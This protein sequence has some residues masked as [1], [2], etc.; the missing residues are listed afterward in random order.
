M[1]KRTNISMVLRF[2]GVCGSLPTPLGSS[3]L[4]EKIVITAN[5][6]RKAGLQ[7]LKEVRAFVHK[8]P[9]PQRGT[10]GGN[11]SCVDV[12][13]GD[14][15]LVFDAGSGLKALGTRLLADGFGAGTGEIHIFMSHTHWDHIQGFPF[16]VP[17]Y[18]PGNKI[19]IY[20]CHT[21][22]K[23][24]FT[25][26]QKSELFP[27][28]FDSMGAD[29]IFHHLVPGKPYQLNDGPVITPIK[30]NHPGDSYG[31]RV[32]YKGKSMVYATDV[33]YAGMKAGQENRY[34][35][36]YRNTDVLISDSQYTLQETFVKK[37]WGHSSALVGVEI[38][39]KAH[40]G[41]VVLFHH[42]PDYDDVTIAGIQEQA[43]QYAKLIPSSHRCKI[44]AGYEGLEIN[45]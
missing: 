21:R 41:T 15:R 14:T 9:L 26:Q 34:L 4:E 43:R 7:S 29:M 11:T 37:F 40:I 42:E 35:D 13:A 45:L 27:I 16:F 33:E 24:R 6:V 32:D 17:A 10:F 2:W 25:T 38:A 3:A 12:M 19:H 5:K 1:K 8:L 23:Q 36:F 39:H 18:I 22:L 30:L 44:I 31:Y 28:P 20:G